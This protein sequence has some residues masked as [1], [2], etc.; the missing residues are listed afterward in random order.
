MPYYVRVIAYN[1]RGYGE[2]TLATRVP[3]D[4]DGEVQVLTIT[5]AAPVA[6]VSIVNSASVTDAYT[7]L[8]ADST[9]R[10]VQEALEATSY[11]QPGGEVVCGDPPGCARSRVRQRFPLHDVSP[12]P[13]THTHTTHPHTPF[14]M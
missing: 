8:S 4:Q 10:E 9:P 2:P 11:I 1:S 12:P 3:V 7:T 13:P 6:T 14:S 5:A